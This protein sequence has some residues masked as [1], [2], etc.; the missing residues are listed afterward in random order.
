MALALTIEH[1][2]WAA[3]QRHVQSMYGTVA[4]VVP[5]TGPGQPVFLSGYFYVENLCK[6]IAAAVE[7]TH[8]ITTM[9]TKQAI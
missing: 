4:K 5:A 9:T 8:P 3:L 1:A 6:D 7:A 2:M